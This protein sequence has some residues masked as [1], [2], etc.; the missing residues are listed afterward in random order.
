MRTTHVRWFLV[1][2]LFVLSAVSYLDRV[3]IS[4]AG[5]NI[6][7]AYH[8]SEVQ[9]GKVFSAMLVGYALFQTVGGRLADRFGTR[10]VLTGGVIW[11][12]IFTALTALVPA[13]LAGALLAFMAVRFFLGAGEAV[14]YP[15]A[16]QFIARW[17]P[18]SERGLANGWIFAGVG[19]G[20]GLT[21]PLI[22]YLM[23]HYGW[24]SSFWVC[25]VVGLLAGAIWFF[26]ARDTPAE[27]S[28]VSAHELAV[29]QSGLTMNPSQGTHSTNERLVSW[30]SVI[31]SKNVWAVTVSYFCYGYV[32]WI[33][34]SWF[35]RY[36]AKVR[37]LD[38]KASAFYSMLPFLAML[39]CCLFGGTLND[40]LTRLHGPRIGRC[41]LA[42]FAIALCG[43]F[44]AFGAQVHSARVASVILAG[45]AGALYLSQSSF[46][47]VTADIAGASSG[48]VS[49]FMNTGNQ[50]GAAITAV[51]TPWIGTHFG[52]TQSFLA[53]AAL[54][55]LGAASW[56]AVDP[57]QT[58]NSRLPGTV[59]SAT[60]AN[61]V[62]TATPNPYPDKPSR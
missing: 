47:S 6:A 58:L 26:A 23:V 2:W 10:L 1:F 55:L 59:G 28:E 57:T 34:F 43:V 53:G 25:S 56:L 29:I 22:T 3:N 14:I 37:G 48:S 32:A 8:L 5:G 41:I 4:I 18:V 16:N 52:W 60:S 13:H 11:W 7:E 17:I 33:F 19:A 12:G 9:L 61:P 62:P 31:R 30:S 36:L 42:A 40:R 45:G 38:L 24:R 20:A 21:P 54:C 35:Y 50:V 39:V 44:L 15:S 46:W 51:L 27:H 49:G